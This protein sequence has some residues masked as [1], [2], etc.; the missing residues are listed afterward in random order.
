MT[1]TLPVTDVFA[2]LVEA[3]PGQVTLPADPNYDADRHGF[4]VAVDQRP[5][6]VVHVQDAQDVVTAVRYA[7]EHGMTVSAQ[8]VGHGAT[9]ATNG[10]ILL[11]TRALQQIHVDPE[12]RIA[13]VGAGV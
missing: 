13:R 10:T 4:A 7:M 8:P 12:Q 2:G 9:L 1:F 11:R 6:A 5:L 3:L